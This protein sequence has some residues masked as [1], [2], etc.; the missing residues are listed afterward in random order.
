LKA[1]RGQASFKR[2]L[3]ERKDAV[4]KEFA[5]ENFWPDARFVI[6]NRAGNVFVKASDLGRDFSKAKLEQRLGEYRAP[7]GMAQV[8]PKREGYPA[9][10]NDPL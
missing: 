2:W 7:E 5:R 10:K 6:A 3:A 4:T 1:H 9:V 8:V